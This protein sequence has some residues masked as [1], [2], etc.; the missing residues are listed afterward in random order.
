MIMKLLF[1]TLILLL[2]FGLLGSAQQEVYSPAEVSQ[3]VYFD[4]SPPLRDMPVLPSG[5]RDGSWKDGVV[6][7]KLNMPEHR[8][9]PLPEA[10]EEDFRGAQTLQGNRSSELLLSVNGVGNV[11]FVLPPDTQGDVGPN[12]YMQMVNLSFAIWNKS[13][14]LLYGPVDN[15]TLWN[16]FPGPWSGSNDGDPIVLYDEQA[17]RWI[18]SQ[19]ALP[20]YPNGPFYELIAVSQTPDPLGAWYRYAF[21]FT[22]MPDY[23]KLGVWHDGYYLAVNSFSSGSLNWAGT[24]VAALDRTKMLAGDPTASMIFFTTPSGGDPSTFQ[25]ADCDGMPAPEGSPALFGYVRDGSPDRFVL[26]TLDADWTTPSNST[27]SQLVTIPVQSYS[28]NIS[29]IPQQGTSTTLQAISDRLM[30]RLQYRNFGSYQSMVTNHTVNVSGHAGVRWYEFRNSGSGWQIYQQGTYSPDNSSRWMGSIAMNSYGDIALGYSISSSSMYP[31]IRYTGRRASDPLGT[32]TFA[33][34]E[35]IAG[36]GA[37][38]SF[39][40]RWGDYSMMSVDP[41]ADTVFWYTQEYYTSTSDQNWKTRIGSFTFGQPLVAVASAFPNT[42]CA[43]SPVQLNVQVTGGGPGDTYSW[44]SEPAGFTSDIRNPQ[45]SPEV[46]TVYTVTITSGGASTSSSVTVNVHPLPS[47]VAPGDLTICA[48]SDVT[49]NSFAQNQDSLQ[50]VTAGDGTFEDQNAARSDYYI[51]PQ[52]IAN[53]SVLLTV[54]AFSDFGCPESSDEVMLTIASPATVEAGEPIETCN[55][56]PILLSASASGFSSLLWTTSG[57]GTFDNNS[58]LD[59]SYT[60]STADI[61]SG[62]VEITLNVSG[63]AP[64]SDVA[65][66]LTL[67][68]HQPAQVNAGEDFSI[69]SGQT[70][71]LNAAGSGYETIEWSSGGDGQFS[72]TNTLVT[73][74]TPGADDLAAGG[75][76]F[77]ITAEGNPLCAETSDELAVEIYPLSQ[78]SAG[79][80]TTI[81]KTASLQVGG[82]ATHASSVLWTTSGNGT[83]DNANLYNTRYLPGTQDTIQG[84]VTLTFTVVNEYGC[85]N[86]VANRNITFAPCVGIE[87]PGKPSI[88]VIP[89]PTDGKFVVEVSGMNAGENIRLQVA[90][91]RGSKVIDQE[92]LN[93]PAVF[94]TTL[95][96]S[97]RTKGVYMMKILFG[98]QTAETK[99]VLQ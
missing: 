56:E 11:D 28:S 1:S 37:Q 20:N 65:D 25:P 39:Y 13:G 98:N 35:I 43:G 58:I 97:G 27:F 5:K 59:A 71:S 17:D 89:N 78:A 45:V 53:G 24:G 6:K 68:F 83:F 44:V 60:P 49:L 36:G 4:V 63:V 12:H 80:D 50:W 19:F 92:Y 70:I 23:P 88:R 51:G 62:T 33:E 82:S 72:A 7:N 87:D 69:C 29:G 55:A 84:T 8:N 57:T 66:A 67:T 95:D 38:T 9:L 32:M 48:G 64:C 73:T 75:V 76:S 54:T 77:V 30:Y 42:I 81:C 46:T 14:T 21:T 86:T 90:D 3:A 52:D 16:G 31:S 74:Y 93:V 79:N 26:Y 99:V 96:L 40:Q 34:Q 10:T 41:A 18:A 94:R 2:G 61:E 47:V 91:F 22:N 85:G 15:K